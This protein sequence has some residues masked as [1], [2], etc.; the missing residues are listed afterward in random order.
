[1]MSKAIRKCRCECGGSNL[2]D[3][4]AWPDANHVIS[5]HA[6]VLIAGFVHESPEGRP[7]QAKPPRK[8]ANEGK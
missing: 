6:G 2:D 7:G 1:M 4:G 8:E 5:R 3:D